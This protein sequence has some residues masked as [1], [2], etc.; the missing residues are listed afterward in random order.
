MF[1]TEALSFLQPWLWAMMYA[2]K[3]VENRSWAPPA[4]IIGNRIGL[5]ASKGIDEGLP[6][7]TIKNLS[8]KVPP[9]DDDPVLH[10]G[11]IVATAVVKEFFRR[12]DTLHPLARSPWFFGEVGWVLDDIRPLEKPLPHRGSLGLW[13]IA[14]PFEVSP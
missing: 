3:D 2:G 9:D 12:V 4:R 5:H 11:S 8:G 7:L 1:V 6:F 10:R 13:K 14:T